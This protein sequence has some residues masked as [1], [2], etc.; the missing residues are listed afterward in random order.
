VLYLDG[1]YSGEWA[2]KLPSPHW[3]RDPFISFVIF[4]FGIV[5]SVP[6]L[7]AIVTLTKWTTIVVR[8]SNSIAGPSLAAIVKFVVWPFVHALGIIEARILEEDTS[9]TL[10]Q[11]NV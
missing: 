4:A 8:W 5:I 7:A 6:V 3:I 11:L 10:N 9:S 1:K 2:E